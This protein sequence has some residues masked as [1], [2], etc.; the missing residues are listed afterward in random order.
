MKK[1]LFHTITIK[2]PSDQLFINKN[3]AVSIVQ[4]LTKNNSIKRREGISS[5]TLKK[6]EH[7][8]HP[9]IIEDGE[10]EDYKDIK[11]RQNKLKKIKKRLEELPKKKLITKEKLKYALSQLPKKIKQEEIKNETE[12]DE[13]RFFKD[14]LEVD[15][16]AS[17]DYNISKLQSLIYNHLFELIDNLYTKKEINTF[18]RNLDIPDNVN[19]Y[20]SNWYNKKGGESVEY[21]DFVSKVIY[22]LL[23]KNVSKDTNKLKLMFVAHNIANDRLFNKIKPQIN[24][25]S[26]IYPFI[27]LKA[28]GIKEYLNRDLEIK[29][30]LEDL[31][32]SSPISEKWQNPN[33]KPKSKIFKEKYFISK[34]PEPENIKQG[35]DE[36]EN[37]MI[38]FINKYSQLLKTE[39]TKKLT[40]KKLETGVKDL[41]KLRHKKNLTNDDIKKWGDKYDLIDKHSVKHKKF[42]FDRVKLLFFD[43]DLE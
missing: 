26:I 41:Y 7:I 30:T 39:S 13:E 12:E 34:T 27:N 11:T 18:E 25:Y 4:T 28:T 2:V 31:S 24:K 35:E 21:K 8:L 1:T 10:V 36:E 22:P 14:Y 6:D 37:E 42:F 9:E 17:E 43:I 29:N 33:Y 40:K 3:G 19:E 16:S 20:I 15:K 38:N 32:N 23:L 5:I